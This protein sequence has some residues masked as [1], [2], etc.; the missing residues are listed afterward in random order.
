MTVTD[1]KEL[2]KAWRKFKRDYSQ[3][4]DVIPGKASFKAGYEYCKKLSNPI[5]PPKY[6]YIIVN[7]D[8]NKPEYKDCFIFPDKN[9]KQ[10]IIVS[11]N[12][13][14]YV[15]RNFDVRFQAEHYNDIF[16][17]DT[18]KQARFHVQLNKDDN[19]NINEVIWKIELDEYNRI[20][21]FCKKNP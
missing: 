11:N 18:R 1:K 5:P 21:S 15:K 2:D 9:R 19:P 14:K 6:G 16:I 20:K 13:C 7:Y 12:V 4:V 8:F 10:C 17:F 3:S